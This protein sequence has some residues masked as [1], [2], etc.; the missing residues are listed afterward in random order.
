MERGEEGS[1]GA[2]SPPL[3][4]THPPPRPPDG[5]NSGL[6][7][8]GYLGYGSDKKP[9]HGAARPLPGRACAAG[10]GGMPLPAQMAP[11]PGRPR[12]V[13]LL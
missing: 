5:P 6:C 11:E 2:N 7:L 13:R 9:H 3:L 12:K 10:M 4:A 1:C 8:D